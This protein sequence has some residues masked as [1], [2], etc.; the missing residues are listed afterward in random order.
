MSVPAERV[1]RTRVPAHG[2]RSLD[3]VVAG[4]PEGGVVLAHH[5]TPGS[6]LL[7][8]AQVRAGAAR[9]LRHVAYARP[10]YAGSDRADGRTVADC[11]ADAAAVL[12]AVG[13]D[14][15]VT[16]GWSGGGPHALACAALLGDR[17]RA[18]ASIA[19]VAPHD[20]DALD[21]TAGMGRENLEEFEAARGGEAVLLP[22]LRAEAEELARVTGPELA[23]SF[24]DLVADVDRDALSGEVADELAAE[25][26]DG[27]REDV[28][29]WLDDDLAFVRPWGFDLQA[30]RVPV[31][32]WQG[33]QDRMVP[34]PHGRW[35]ATHVAGV[36]ARFHDDHGHISLLTK[37]YGEVLDDLVAAAR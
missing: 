14:I 19:G 26:R 3:V 4:P 13:A 6:P 35:L 37:H 17:V 34:E 1:S 23:R 22:Y 11:A 16:T 29:G 30:I 5:G 31:M 33:G 2:A 7:L 20:A 12:E 8:T 21:W 18:A 32:V 15:C 25:T 28:W 24:G 27:L 10:G 36:Q 9:G